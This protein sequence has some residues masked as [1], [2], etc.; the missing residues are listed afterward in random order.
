MNKQYTLTPTEVH[1]DQYNVVPRNSSKRAVHPPVWMKDYVTHVIDSVHPYSLAIYMSY[2]NFAVSYQAYLSE[3]SV[4]N[5]PTTYEMA[6][7]DQRWVEAMKPSSYVM[8]LG[9]L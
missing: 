2:D 1:I 6:V 9:R 7:K 3:M 4:D 8:V 5:E